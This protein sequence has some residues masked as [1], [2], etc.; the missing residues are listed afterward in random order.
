LFLGYYRNKTF[1]Y[2]SSFIS[3]NY[4]LL[5]SL[6]VPKE[7]K[8]HVMSATTYVMN[9]YAMSATTFSGYVNSPKLKTDI[10]VT[11]LLYRIS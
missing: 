6:K 3:L 2:L 5:N 10:I 7:N 1:G 9:A 11:H 8:T 4:P